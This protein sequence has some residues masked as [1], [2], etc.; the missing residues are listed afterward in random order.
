[1]VLQQY[2]RSHSAK[3]SNKIIVKVARK[4][5]SRIWHVIKNEE[6]YQC[7]VKN[8]TDLTKLY[9]TQK[10]KGDC[11]TSDA[12][13]HSR[14]ENLLQSAPG[15][16][17]APFLIKPWDICLQLRIDEWLQIGG[18]DYKVKINECTM[19]TDVFCICSNYFVPNRKKHQSPL[20][21]KFFKELIMNINL[22]QLRYALHRNRCYAQTL[23]QFFCT[24]RWPWGPWCWSIL[25][26]GIRIQISIYLGSENV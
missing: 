4:L 1:M 16:H 5:V 15:K 21:D 9:S 19:S 20:C 26:W 6:S 23:V 17:A 8:T 13:V 14:P 7:E 25:F 24:A 11:K 18:W 22:H 12:A 10:Q 3:P 2:Y